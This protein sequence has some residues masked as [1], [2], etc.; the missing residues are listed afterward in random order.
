[1]NQQ[2]LLGSWVRRFLL[3]HLTVERN[4]SRNT[5]RSYRDTFCLLIPFAAERLKRPVDRIKVTELSADLVRTF[6]TYLKE[7]RNC[8]TNT[9]NQRLAGIH[10]LALFVG[11]RSP[12]HLAWCSEVRAVPF[13]RS[14]RTVIHYLDKPEMDAL[15]AAVNQNSAQGRRDHAMLLFLY[16][17]GARAE[18]AA[19]LTIADLHFTPS[20]WNGQAYVQ[21]SGKG[22]RTRQ[23]PLWP[24]TI[25][26]IRGLIANREPSQHVFLNRRHVPIT[27]YGIYDVVKRYAR[28]AAANVPSIAAKQVSPHI[29]RHT[30]ATHL[31]RAG[32]DINTIRGWLGH[33]SLNTTNVYAEVD[34]EMKAK[35]LSKCE[36]TEESKRDKHWRDQPC[37]MEFL[38][39]L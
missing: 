1:M 7:V 29:I 5:Q 10:A 13:K 15:M 17:S 4:L 11:K 26:E 35:A 33:V 18:E 34:L 6:L 19:R 20:D 8:G 21:I 38:R 22:G 27:R 23:C 3:E 31:L 14:A 39:T 28:R 16:N 12:E 30:T 2:P 9:H 36:V 32:V 24:L 25:H 37:L